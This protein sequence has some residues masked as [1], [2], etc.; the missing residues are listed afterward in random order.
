MM[1]LRKVFFLILII[2][3]INE[4]EGMFNILKKAPTPSPIPMRVRTPTNIAPSA[5]RNSQTSTSSSSTIHRAGSSGA[6]FHSIEQNVNV[7]NANM[8][9]LGE[10]NHL[11]KKFQIKN[12][13]K[14]LKNS[15]IGVAAI[16]GGITIIRSVM[17]IGQST[18]EKNMTIAKTESTST[19]VKPFIRKNPIHERSTTV[20]RSLPHTTTTTAFNGHSLICS[21]DIKVRTLPTHRTIPSTSVYNGEFLFICKLFFRFYIQFEF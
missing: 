18:D 1:C 13:P 11:L 15:A 14:V 12:A 9:T 5:P 6:S 19:T 7:E 16:G 20:R 17:P 2:F 8:A 4:I 21:Y 3:A 10:R